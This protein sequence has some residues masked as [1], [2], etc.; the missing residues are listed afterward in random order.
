MNK[1]ELIEKF[2][3]DNFPGSTSIVM[4]NHEGQIYNYCLQT[5]SNSTVI[6]MLEVMKFN[7]LKS[8]SEEV[9]DGSAED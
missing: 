4:I 7:I 5:I 1:K 8:M 3:D 9:K 6:S 2:I